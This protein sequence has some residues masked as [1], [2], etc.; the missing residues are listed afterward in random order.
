[1]RFRMKKIESFKELK[2][3]MI[4]PLNNPDFYAL[5]L[6]DDRYRVKPKSVGHFSLCNSYDIGCSDKND[7][8]TLW[9]IIID[10]YLKNV[11]YKRFIECYPNSTLESF[12]NVK[13]LLLNALASQNNL[14]NFIK[15]NI[16]SLRKMLGITKD[17]EVDNGG[18]FYFKSQYLN[19]N[20]DADSIRLGNIKHRLYLTA[21]SNNRV[22]IA[23]KIV[24][25]CNQKNLPYNFKILM[26]FRKNV[27]NRQSD[28][29]V[30]YLTDEI[31]VVEYINFINDIIDENEELKKHI[32]KPSPH[33][34]IIND[35]LGY[36]F[37]PNLH[38]ERLSYSAL[39]REAVKNI[40]F[41]SIANNILQYSGQEQS[42]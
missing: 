7:Y 17:L 42:K 22:C 21:D 33:L 26:D 18:W 12:E 36:G 4:N 20:L 15:R 16:D 38:E 24:E 8:Y 9:N 35:Y 5:L 23:N 19:P 39:L 32:F 13:K 31:Q 10:Q 34:G 11:D 27:T 3:I 14:E 30:I 1:M 40:P 29:V 28:T 6:G 41:E 25:K 37:E 2:S